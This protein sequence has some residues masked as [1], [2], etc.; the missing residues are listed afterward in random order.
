MTYSSKSAKRSGSRSVIAILVVFALICIW[1]VAHWVQQQGGIAPGS[2]S[3][4]VLGGTATIERADAGTDAPLAAGKTATMQTGDTVTL[5]DDARA[6]LTLGNNQTLELGAGTS[7]TILQLQRTGLLRTL[8]ATVALQSGDLLAQMSDTMT[9]SSNLRVETMAV[10]VEATGATLECE[11]VSTNETHVA[12]YKGLATV[13]MGEQTTQL[14]PGQGVQAVL[15]GTL[16]L[17]TVEVPATIEA[18]T[19]VDIMTAPT[20]TL[21]EA[22]QT[23]FPPAETPTVP[24]DVA[25]PAGG[26][27]YTVQ[28]GDTLYSIARKFGVSWE[29]IYDANRDILSSPDELKAGQQLRIPAS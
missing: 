7:V 3:L 25:A 12:V 14:E 26:Q 8:E 6:R 5:S 9:Q 16:T 24:G 23:L 21:T 1:G 19:P 20:S 18:A 2:A 10:T 29:T 4:L 15:G 28:S 27:L 22:E 11:V 13:S 17:V